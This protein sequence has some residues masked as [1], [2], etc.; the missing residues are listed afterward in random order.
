MFG[1]QLDSLVNGGPPMTG[2]H[3]SEEILQRH[4]LHVERLAAS[5]EPR[6]IE[7]VADDVLDALGLVADDREI[8]LASVRIE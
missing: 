5:L 3:A 8:S 4:V 1:G 2:D 6:Q 7:Q